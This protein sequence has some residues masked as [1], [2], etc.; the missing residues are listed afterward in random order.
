MVS[1]RS[2][3]HVGCCLPWLTAAIGA[4]LLTACTTDGQPSRP[5]WPGTPVFPDFATFT[6]VNADGYGLDLPNPGRPEPLHLTQFKTP[7]GIGCGFADDG[8]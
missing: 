6:A 2:F 1:V 8:A 3:S 7:A 4:V 5:A